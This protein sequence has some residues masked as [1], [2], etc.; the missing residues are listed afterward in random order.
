MQKC[1]TKDLKACFKGRI[2]QVG[3]RKKSVGLLGMRLIENALI[4]EEGG[5]VTTDD[6]YEAAETVDEEQILSENETMVKIQDEQTVKIDDQAVNRTEDSEHLFQQVDLAEQVENLVQH[7]EDRAPVSAYSSEL[8][9]LCQVKASDFQLLGYEEVT[10]D[11][12]W[13][14]VK[15]RVKGEVPLHQMVDDILSLHIGTLMNYLTISA[16]KGEFLDEEV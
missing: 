13:D 10:A 14:C 1:L 8:M 6:L 11:T 3:G 9:E 15:S 4:N 2:S 16:Y 7:E 12:V 5:S